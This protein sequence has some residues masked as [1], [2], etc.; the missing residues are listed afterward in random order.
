M[1]FDLHTYNA[2][3][4]LTK[5]QPLGAVLTVGRQSLDTPLAI[6]NV[7]YPAYEARLKFCDNLLLAMGA[8]SV[9]SIDYSDYEQPTYVAD[10]GRPLA[11]DK[12]F[13]TIIDAGSLEHIFDIGTALQNIHQLLKPHGRVVHVL[14]VNNLNGHGFWQL[15]SDLMYSIYSKANG[16]DGAEVYYISNYDYEVWYRAPAPSPGSRTEIVS[17]EPISLVCLAAKIDHVHERHV[18]QPFYSN[19]WTGEANASSK[20]SFLK[21]LLPLGGCL[22]RWLRNCIALLR[23]ASN[24]RYSVSGPGFERV[25]VKD[26]L[27][28]K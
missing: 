27:A 17:L 25:I 13:D 26:L 16:Y 12:R 18:V 9:E 3:K 20:R 14:P 22:R 1:G 21:S 19:A 28:G 24:G 23:L 2:I 6:V 15:S 8:Q 11:I 7:D 10:F 4:Y 5:R